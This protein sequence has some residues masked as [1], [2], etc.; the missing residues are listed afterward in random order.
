MFPGF[1][2]EPKL[3]KAVCQ[4]GAIRGGFGKKSR[5]VGIILVVDTPRD[6]SGGSTNA[7]RGN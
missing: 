4:A 5:L 2:T 7:N 6:D 3:I 1:L